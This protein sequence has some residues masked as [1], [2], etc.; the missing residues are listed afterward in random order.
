MGEATIDLF[1]LARAA[2]TSGREEDRAGHFRVRWEDGDGGPADGGLADLSLFVGYDGVGLS[3][4]GVEL[5]IAWWTEEVASGTA[6]TW[7]SVMGM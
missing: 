7:T 6:R 1:G 3:L 2:G 5:A 4:S